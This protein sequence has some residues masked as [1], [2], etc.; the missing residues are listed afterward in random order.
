[1]KDVGGQDKIRA[2]WKHY[3]A[4]TQGLI[5]VVDAAD[6]ERIEEAKVELH[7]ILQDREMSQVTVLVFANKQDLPGALSPGEMTQRLALNQL[8]GQRRVWNCQPA[9]AI[10]GDGLMEGLSWLSR[11]IP[12]TNSST[13]SRPT[14]VYAQ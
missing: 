6:V 1:M 9:C 11:S 14:N 3:F 7:R 13:A 5:Y 8:P 10:N 2:L 4:G 12:E